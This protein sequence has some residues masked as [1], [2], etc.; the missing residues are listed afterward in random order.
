I[1]PS[2]KGEEVKLSIALARLCEEDPTLHAAQDPQTGEPLLSGIG[3]L[4]LQVA[5]ERLQSRF[6]LALEVKA[7]NIAYRE[8]VTARSEGHHRLKKQT[9]GAGQFA[10]VFLRIEPRGRGA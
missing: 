10:E 3:E 1:A 8:T 2:K 6:H 9:G 5:I 7:P 4:H